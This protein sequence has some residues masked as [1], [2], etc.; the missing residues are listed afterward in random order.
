MRQQISNHGNMIDYFPCPVGKITNVQMAFCISLWL[1]AG[2]FSIISHLF[3]GKS[4]RFGG[5]LFHFDRLVS[6][7]DPFGP[8]HG[9]FAFPYCCFCAVLVLFSHIVIV[10]CLSLVFFLL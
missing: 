9:H 3:G 5:C 2:L 7:F 8:L 1:F 6:Q 10:F 4:A